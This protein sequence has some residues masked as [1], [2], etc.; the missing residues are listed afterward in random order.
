VTGGELVDAVPAVPR[1]STGARPIG[2]FNT[3]SG[4]FW[5]LLTA[6]LAFLTVVVLSWSVVFIFGIGA[7]IALL[8]MP[9]VNWLQRRG[10]PRALAAGVMVLILVVLVGALIF[11][12]FAIIINQG[13]P[14]LQSLPQ[15]VDEIYAQLTALGLPD[16]IQSAID[17]LFGAINENLATI[18]PGSI[19]LGFLQSVLGFVAML[20]S[21]TIVPF[22]I[23][24]LI[25]DQPGMAADVSAQIPDSLRVHINAVLHILRVD[26]VNYFKAELIVGGIM[27]VIVTVGML[28]IGAFVGGPLGE[29]AFFLGLI[30]AA[31]EFLPTIGPIIAMIP[32]LL[33]AATISPFAFV[34]VLIFY[35]I[36]FQVESAI[37]VPTIEGQVI[38]FRPATILLLIAMGFAIG[39][40][41]G[42]IVVLPV[43]SIARDL[44]RYFFQATAPPGMVAPEPPALSPEQSVTAGATSG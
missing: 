30:A 6:G 20:L 11:G 18:D 33:I 29:F 16:V 39:G 7:A 19:A 21:L 3:D 38:S 23:F 42:A 4:R 37:L 22:F 13:I 9:V 25:K 2:P 43:A 10:V 5:L 40:V 31:L 35:L 12:I 44:F 26:F 32:A 15:F 1:A 28:V 41:I 14:F 36:A 24:Y 34:V 27:G 17:A 8:M